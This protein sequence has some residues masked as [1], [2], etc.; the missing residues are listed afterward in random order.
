MSD[1]SGIGLLLVM[2]IVALMFVVPR[3]VAAA[4]LL[5]AALYLAFNQGLLVGAFHFYSIRIVLFAGLVRT[6][7][8]REFVVVGGL[9][10]MD[11]LMLWS[12]LWALLCCALR[13]EPAGALTF[14]LG[15]VFN[16][17]V[18]Y[19]LLRVFLQS[20]D[21]ITRVL[22]TLALLLVPVALEMAFER[23]TAQNY[24]SLLGGDV[25]Q[26]AVREGRARAQ[27]PFAH[28]ILAGTVGSVCLPL[29]AALWQGSVLTAVVGLLACCTMI[30]SSASSGPMMSAIF[31][32]V[33]LMAFA[34]HPWMRAV[35]YAALLGYVLLDLAMKAPAYFLIARIDLAGGSTGWHRSALIQAAIDHFDEWWLAGTDYTRHWLSSGVG[36]SAEHVDITNHYIAMGVMAGFPMVF[37]FGATIVQ[38][39]SFVGQ[40]VKGAQAISAQRQFFVWALGASLFSHALSLVSVSLFDQSFVFLH[41]VL[42]LIA[43][44]YAVQASPVPSTAQ[45]RAHEPEPEPEPEPEQ[46][47]APNEMTWAAAA[48]QK[49]AQEKL[50]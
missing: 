33:A 26:S 43:S 36:W 14:A 5:M 50:Q 16:H 20:A 12:S 39:F 13:P 3:H 9:N 10:R 25:L 15:F 38:G 11:W 46:A 34:I 4:L 44:S 32:L 22:K 31:A 42:A 6:L 1:L 35:R 19:C 41:L 2:A 30:F 18:C 27:G 7:V 47:L 29:F 21:D 23:S 17:L 37:L 48:Q 28:A 40:M 8:R 24:F 49:W 45:A